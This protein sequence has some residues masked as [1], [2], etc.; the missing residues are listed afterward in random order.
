ASKQ[1]RDGGRAVSE[2]GV[3][4][5]PKLFPVFGKR[6][7]ESGGPGVSV[8]LESR[9]KRCLRGG[10]EVFIIPMITLKS[11]EVSLGGPAAS[12]ISIDI[13]ISPT[14]LSVVPL[15]F[16]QLI[17]VS[18]MYDKFKTVHLDEALLAGKGGLSHKRFRMAQDQS[19]P[20]REGLL[21]GVHHVQDSEPRHGDTIT[22]ILRSLG[23]VPVASFEVK[24]K[25]NTMVV[26]FP[27]FND[28]EMSDS[29]SSRY[30]EVYSRRISQTAGQ[31]VG[32]DSVSTGGEQPGRGWGAPG[33]SRSDDYYI[34]VF[35]N[36]SHPAVA[37]SHNI[38]FLFALETDKEGG[39]GPPDHESLRISLE[40]SQLR[41]QLPFVRNIGGGYSI[42]GAATRGVPRTGPEDAPE[43]RDPILDIFIPSV[44]SCFVLSTSSHPEGEGGCHA[45]P[46]TRGVLFGMVSIPIVFAIDGARIPVMDDTFILRSYALRRSGGEDS[47]RDFS[48][49]LARLQDEISQEEGLELSREE[50]P[51][52]ARCMMS[53]P[54]LL[55][56]IINAVGD[57]YLQ[58]QAN[59]NNF[60]F[61]FSLTTFSVSAPYI[62]RINSWWNDIWLIRMR[63][64]RC[65]G[66]TMR[67]FYVDTRSDTMNISSFGVAS[68]STRLDYVAD[69]LEEVPRQEQHS[70]KRDAGGP[71]FR[72]DGVEGANEVYCVNR[73]DYANFEVTSPLFFPLDDSIPIV[74]AL[75]V[76]ASLD[77]R[78]RP[79]N[80]LEFRPEDGFVLR[81]NQSLKDFNL[82]ILQ[83][84]RRSGSGPG[85]P[86]PAS[87]N[88]Q[89]T[90]DLAREGGACPGSR[91]TVKPDPFLVCSCREPG[92]P[93]RLDSSLSE[94][95]MLNGELAE[96]GPDEETPARLDHRLSVNAEQ[97]S[98]QRGVY[99]VGGQGTGGEDLSVIHEGSLDYFA[100]ANHAQRISRSQKKVSG[101]LSGWISL[102][103]KLSS[104]SSSV[105][106]APRDEDPR[107]GAQEAVSSEESL[108]T[109]PEGGP[110]RRSFSLFKRRSSNEGGGGLHLSPIH[111]G[112]PGNRTSESEQKTRRESRHVAGGSTEEERIFKF[113][114]SLNNLEIW[115]HRDNVKEN[116]SVVSR[117][118]LTKDEI[119]QLTLEEVA[120]D[121]M[122]KA[123]HCV[124]ASRSTRERGRDRDTFRIRIQDPHGEDSGPRLGDF[125][126]EDE[127]EDEDEELEFVGCE[128]DL[129]EADLDGGGR[130]GRHIRAKGGRGAR[131]REEGADGSLPIRTR[132]LHSDG[133]SRPT[134]RQTTTTSPSRAGRDEGGRRGGGVSGGGSGARGRVLQ[135]EEGGCGSSG[136]QG[137]RGEGEPV[138]ERDGVLHTAEL[139][140]FPVRIREEALAQFGVLP[141]SQQGESCCTCNYCRITSLR[142]Y[143]YLH[144]LNGRNIYL[145]LTKA[146]PDRIKRDFLLLISHLKIFSTPS[147][148]RKS[149]ISKYWTGY[150]IETEFV[151]SEVT[152]SV[153]MDI[154]QEIKL[155]ISNFKEVRD[156][157]AYYSLV[158]SRS[159]KSYIVP[160]AILNPFSPSETT[161]PA[162]IQT[163]A[164]AQAQAHA[165]TRRSFLSQVLPTIIRGSGSSAGV[166]GR[167]FRRAFGGVIPG[168]VRVLALVELDAG[169]SGDTAL[170]LGVSA[171]PLECAL[172]SRVGEEALETGDAAEFGQ[173]TAVRDLHEQRLGGLFLSQGDG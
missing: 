84:E 148:V 153:S 156:S 8:G 4:T 51:C 10:R 83:E 17:D 100:L 111:E 9:H 121:W 69:G 40:I 169:E 54:E 93:A 129:Q 144:T 19:L 149:S 68:R 110:R 150:H 155:F 99:V 48:R 2:L 173:E 73:F 55:G 142:R 139:R 96:F 115:F 118:N 120:V 172:H 103:Q 46:E 127:D 97:V 134:T 104:N 85:K 87:E 146:V 147:G 98:D 33:P 161:P 72:W 122:S 76:T 20:G 77:E 143:L 47:T 124:P 81:F 66:S 102:R 167:E 41:V 49:D 39:G 162:Q 32:P 112:G 28:L 164:H 88:H 50:D 71:M 6:P 29:V 27:E 125:E 101:L 12:S 7:M 95:N 159:R 22:S 44:N 25:F 171:S 160:E 30:F 141:I 52:F 45:A 75:P 13:T 35:S 135:G 24:S 109:G 62:Q 163:Q 23:S 89:G 80:S 136:G 60:R 128:V 157:I 152:I 42:D 16:R 106:Q 113:Q 138:S 58:I 137:L 132:S 92:R 67:Y 3:R 151:I 61:I 105:G 130:A 117:E 86:G 126:D 1:G 90:G 107:W 5:E 131:R 123:V 65:P 133:T 63:Y 21:F 70:S 94:S 38:S 114:V 53:R 26:I 11:N 64:P 145:S 14:F 74:L 59:L 166:Q 116:M 78:V 18:F 15:V 79:W 43:S 34:S 158:Y 82:E 91:A 36:S 57:H 140:G 31:H 119:D 170:L 108:Q 168:L 165:Q 154:L 37:F 56:V